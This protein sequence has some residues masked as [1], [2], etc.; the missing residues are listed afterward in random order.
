MTVVGSQLD[1]SWRILCRTG[2]RSRRSVGSHG[3]GTGSW[4]RR[5]Q[6]KNQRRLVAGRRGSCKWGRS[7]CMLTKCC[8]SDNLEKNPVIFNN[9]LILHL[10][11]LQDLNV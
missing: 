9:I 8:G 4:S 7:R 3:L 10:G 11:Q 1:T 5:S 6:T 2:R